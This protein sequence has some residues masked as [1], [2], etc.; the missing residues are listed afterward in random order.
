MRA[1]EEHRSAVTLLLD[2]KSIL[3]FNPMTVWLIS[4]IAG[5]V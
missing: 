1:V 5:T 2:I 3:I 4:I